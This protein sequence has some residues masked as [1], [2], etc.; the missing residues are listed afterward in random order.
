MTLLIEIVQIADMRKRNWNISKRMV[1][2]PQTLANFLDSTRV[3]FLKLH[4]V[5]AKQNARFRR[6]FPHSDPIY[7]RVEDS[8]FG[9]F[10][11]MPRQV[12]AFANVVEEVASS[13]GVRHFA[14]WE[15]DV[16]CICTMRSLG[17][18]DR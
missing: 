17:P 13:S 18:V 11:D 2:D 3:A 14:S 16:Q 9:A 7:K 5:V 15:Q 6:L 12:H 1:Y 4:E 8:F 10:D